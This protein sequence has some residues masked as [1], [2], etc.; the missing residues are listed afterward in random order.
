M[1]ELMA[2][3]ED[4]DFERAKLIG[5]AGYFITEV[6]IENHFI[7]ISKQVRD[8]IIFGGLFEQ[9]LIYRLYPFGTIYCV[10]SKMQ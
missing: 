7:K 3:Y 8:R 1:H 4:G 2:A 5:Q 10:P 9:E 6:N